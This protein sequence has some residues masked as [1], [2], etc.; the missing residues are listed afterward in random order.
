MLEIKSNYIYKLKHPT[1]PCEINIDLSYDKEMREAWLP[2]LRLID[3]YLIKCVGSVKA[4]TP[5]CDP[6]S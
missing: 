6:V 5:G 2:Y 1:Q 4:S 3:E